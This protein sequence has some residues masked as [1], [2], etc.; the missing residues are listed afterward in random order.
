M[1]H[2]T[3]NFNNSVS[4]NMTS[5]LDKT[6]GWLAPPICLG[7]GH[8]GAAL[9]Q[10]CQTAEIIPYGQHCAFCGR[11]SPA[12]RTCKKCRRSAP[13]HVWVATDYIGL[14]TALVKAYK[15]GHSRFAASELADSML[16]TI[17]LFNYSEELDKLNYLITPVPTAT[18]RVRERSFDH[19]DL[20]A[21]TV[22][23]HLNLDHFRVLGRLDQHRQVGSK[24]SLR[25]KQ[26]QAS[27]AALR[28]D[29][30]KGRNILI[31]DDVITTGAT[32]K[33]VTKVL[34][35]AGAKRVDAL[36]FAKSI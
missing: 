16:S 9:C 27:Y 22:A 4:Y 6:I 15:F 30:I 32:L 14:A 7:C 29:K 2:V 33:A 17:K 13:R 18:S 25:L 36:V 3:L 19:A 26:S 20:L 24:R 8:E 10:A 1:Q 35:Q 12:C 31:I 11:V 28:P 34:R 5:L 21:A 23:K